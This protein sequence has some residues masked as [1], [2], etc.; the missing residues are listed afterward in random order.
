LWERVWGTPWDLHCRS[1]PRS[2]SVLCVLEVFALKSNPLI[3]QV[4]SCDFL[5]WRCSPSAIGPVDSFSQVFVGGFVRHLSNRVQPEFFGLFRK[6]S[7]LSENPWPT[8]ITLDLH[9]SCPH[10]L[11]SCFLG[12]H[13]LIPCISCV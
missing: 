10:S 11:V 7:D 8:P 13:S 12:F 6:F 1:P 5:W 3:P 2:S 4:L 9:Y